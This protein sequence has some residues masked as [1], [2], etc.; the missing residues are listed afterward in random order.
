MLRVPWIKNDEYA[1]SKML[2]LMFSMSLWKESQF[3]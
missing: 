2:N 3:L 1:F